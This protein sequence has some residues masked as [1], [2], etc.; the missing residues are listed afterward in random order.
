MT[1]EQVAR[2]GTHTPAS[3]VL[4]NGRIV[5]AWRETVA[6]KYSNLPGIRGLYNFMALGNVEEDAVMKQLLYWHTKSH[7]PQYHKGD[8]S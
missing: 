8:E 3:V 1:R 4:E 7:A 6:K 2:Q 5:Q